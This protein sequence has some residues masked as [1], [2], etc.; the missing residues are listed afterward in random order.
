[1][2]M[3]ATNVGQVWGKGLSPDYFL[4]E[5]ALYF[6]ALPSKL[7]GRVSVRNKC[8]YDP[9]TPRPTPQKGQAFAHAPTPPRACFV[10]F[11]HSRP[12]LA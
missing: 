7:G 11:V 4:R 5:V 1:M 10:R 8:A 6:I 2:H 9:D 3:A 12:F